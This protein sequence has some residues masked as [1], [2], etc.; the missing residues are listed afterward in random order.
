[1]TARRTIVKALAAIPAALP[2]EGIW[3]ANNEFSRQALVIENSNYPNALLI[4]PA[5]IHK[6]SPDC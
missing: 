4:N 6:P 2:F 1:M 5:T 3:A